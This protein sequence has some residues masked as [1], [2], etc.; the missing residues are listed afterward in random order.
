MKIIIFLMWLFAGIVVMV[1]G[2][3]TLTYGLCWSI[4]MLHLLEDVLEEIIDNK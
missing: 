4:L 2:P 1:S 3:T